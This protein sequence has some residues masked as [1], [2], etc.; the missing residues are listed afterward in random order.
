[1]ADLLNTAQ[2]AVT[3]DYDLLRD[4]CG[5]IEL[6]TLGLVALYGDDR[7]GWLQGQVP[8]DIKELTPGTFA[9]FCLCESTGH[10]RSVLDAWALSDRFLMACPRETLPAVLERVQKMVV[11]EDVRAEDLT[12]KYRLFSIQ[13]PNATRNLSQFLELPKL[14]AGEVAVG[15]ASVFVT[16]SD[17]TGSGGWDVWIPASARSTIAKI[18]DAWPKIGREAF[19]IARLEAG[20]PA[21]GSDMNSRTLPP[22][23]GPAFEARYVSYS[24]GCYTGQEVLMRMHSRGHTNRTWM[25]L[26]SEDPLEAGASVAHV[27]REDA[28]VVTSAAL[29]PDYGYIGA[30]MLRNEAAFQG[31]TVKVRTERG[32]SEAEVRQMPLLRLD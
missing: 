8:N 32:E 26:L 12:S 24:K 18:A 30:A 27:R 23:M 5:L 19:E 13:G 9:S 7:K 3:R 20:I 6:E 31:E 22:E 15:K 17:R 1:M 10:L 28:G 4:D 21:W 16:R 2:D 14:D 25:A 11:L 29:S